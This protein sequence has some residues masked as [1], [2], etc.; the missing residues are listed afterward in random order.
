MSAAPHAHLKD[1]RGRHVTGV[2]VRPNEGY[3]V[4]MADVLRIRYH[5]P[6]GEGDRHFCDVYWK[7]RVLRLFTV[8]SVMFGEEAGR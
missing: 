4:G 1:A 2:I 5:W 6:A 3:A 7:D 8:E